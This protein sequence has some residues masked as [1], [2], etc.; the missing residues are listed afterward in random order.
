MN[1]NKTITALPA[2]GAFY[3]DNKMNT[4]QISVE[5][6]RLSES[7]HDTNDKILSAIEMIERSDINDDK[8]YYDNE[9]W[10]DELQHNKE[11][12]IKE[13]AKYSVTKTICTTTGLMKVKALF[14]SGGFFFYRQKEHFVVSC[15]LSGKSIRKFLVYDHAVDF[16]GDLAEKFENF[17]PE[18]QLSEIANYTTNWRR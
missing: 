4:K 1:L 10:L 12:L 7:L 14:Q 11:L 13:I 18:K 3:K 6:I 2:G 8:T 16:C 17:D 9:R 5:L 15:Q